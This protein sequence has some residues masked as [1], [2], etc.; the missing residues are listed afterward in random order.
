[1]KT[2]VSIIF[3][4][5]LYITTYAQVTTSSIKGVVN[6]NAGT[7]MGANVMAVHQPTGTKY[8]SMTDMEGRFNIF[9]MRI[10]GPYTITISYV[11]YLNVEYTEVY[12]NLGQAMNVDIKLT[13]D[14][15][16]LETIVLSARKNQTF[17][18][19]RTGAETSIG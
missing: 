1:M 13:E 19:D 15:Q 3:T 7:L 10:G 8:G 4:L 16:Q 18:S 14:S 11:G 5:F 6:D 2:T 17:N 9:N 12:L